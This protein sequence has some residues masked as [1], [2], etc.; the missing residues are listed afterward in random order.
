VRDKQKINPVSRMFAKTR[1]TFHNKTEIP[2]RVPDKELTV[3]G[4]MEIE[5]AKTEITKKA[6][7]INIVIDES[8]SMEDLCEDHQRKIDQIEHVVKNIMEFILKDCR[9]ADV[10]IGVHSFNTR[11]RKIFDRVKITDDNVEELI[12]KIKKIRPTDGTNIENALKTLKNMERPTRTRTNIIMS[13]GDANDGE[14]NNDKL[15]R[16]VDSNAT[17]YFIGFGLE[18]NPL[19]F[20]ALS[21]RERS[22]YYFVDKIEKSGMIYGEVL[23]NILFNKYDGVKLEIVSDGGKAYLYDHIKNEWRSEIIIGNISSE[24]KKTIHIMSNTKDRVKIRVTGYDVEKEEYVEEMIEWNNMCEEDL[25][26]WIYRQQ[27]MEMIYRAKMIDK[28]RED[29]LT[30]GLMEEETIVSKTKREMKAF[31]VEMNEYIKTNNL[32][33]D[34][35][36]RSLCEDIVVIYR[37]VGTEH[38]FMYSCSRQTSQGAQRLTTNTDVPETPYRATIKHTRQN[39]YLSTYPDSMAYATVYGFMDK[40]EEP[41][42]DM[43]EEAEFDNLIDTILGEPLN[44][45]EWSATQTNVLNSINKKDAVDRSGGGGLFV[46]QEIE[47]IISES[48]ESK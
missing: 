48:G 24:M 40:D 23:Y 28:D 39:K 45:T 5:M 18:H 25:T 19:L 37:T 35:L 47:P 41:V 14:T 7:E 12:T 2:F 4:I 32:S 3:F 38:G 16:M 43:K 31:V 13:D 46:S 1:I 10:Q 42:F 8:G 44:Q 9:E 21:S 11:V 36:M 33:D 34:K 15:A 29:K 17:N 26:R 20:A 27:T 6:Q 22:H 30:D